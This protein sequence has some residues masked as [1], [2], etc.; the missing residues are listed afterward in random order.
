MGSWRGGPE[1]TEE[2][3][4]LVRTLRNR[5]RA[6]EE[7]RGRFAS[8]ANPVR[9]RLNLRWSRDALAR[10]LLGLHVELKAFRRWWHGSRRGLLMAAEVKRDQKI[11]ERRA[12]IAAGQAEY[13]RRRGPL[14]TADKTSLGR[15][16]GT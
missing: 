15:G 10:A 13:R 11:L 8:L 2:R 3:R 5:I 14:E 16:G 9:R 7:P 4:R 1:G 6:L 12:L